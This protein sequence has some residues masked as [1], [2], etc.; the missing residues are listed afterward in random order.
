MKL[1]WIWWRGSNSRDLGWVEY[2]FIDITV[3][4]TLTHSVWPVRVLFMGQIDLLKINN[5][6]LEYVM[7]YNCVKIIC[8][9]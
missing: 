4:S 8:I 3:S 1:N 7:Q 9:W 2:S 5:V 6:Q